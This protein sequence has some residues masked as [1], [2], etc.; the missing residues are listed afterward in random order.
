MVYSTFA[1]S[2]PCLNIIHFLIF[3]SPEYKSVIQNLCSHQI[4]MIYVCSYLGYI[5]HF[6]YV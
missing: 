3:I 2:K 4:I 1:L 5:R 6:F